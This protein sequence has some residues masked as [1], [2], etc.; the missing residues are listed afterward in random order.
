MKRK[1]LLF[2]VLAAMFLPLAVNAQQALPY[3][4]GFENNNLSADGWTAYVTSSYSGIYS[5]AAHTGSYGFRFN[6]SEEDGYLV[7]PLLTGTDNGVEVSFYYKEYS[8]SYGDEQFYVGYT[9]DESVTDPSAFDYGSI[10]TAST[11]WAQYEN[12]LPAGTKRVA[13][14]YVY[15]DA[16]YLFL[17]DFSFA[18][19]STCPRPKNLA[20]GNITYTTADLSWQ[21]TSN[22]Y[23]L[24]Y[25]PWYQ[26]GEDQITTGV[27]TTY[28]FDLS[29]YSG[30]G[31]VAIRHYDVSDMFELNVDDIVVTNAAGTTLYSQN[32]ETGDIPS[33]ITNLDLD[34]DGHVWGIRSY[35]T[36]A[37]GNA[38]CNGNYC[39][40][41]ASYASGALTPDNWL[42]I[43]GIE[44]GGEITLVARGQD[45]EWAS[46]NFGVFVCPDANPIEV[47]VTTTTYNATGLEPNTPYSWQVKGICDEEETGWVSSFFKTMDSRVVFAYDG[48]WDDPDNWVDA[49][50]NPADVPT[51]VNNV[52]VNAE[53]IIAAGVVALANKITIGEGSI[54]IKDGGQLK[55]NSATVRVTMEKEITGVGEE[56]W[57]ND[58][59]GGFY[60]ISSPFSGRTLFD[61]TSEWNHVEN[62]LE[63]D[64]D[65]YAFDPTRNHLEWINYL[66]EP[67]HIYF[68]S[69]NG[70]A[71]LLYGEGYLYASKEDNLL[72]FK[73]SIGKSN[74]YSETKEYEYNAGA[75]YYLNGW[76]LVGNFFA[77]DAYIN[78]IDDE[79]NVLDADF[80][81]MNA[82]GD[83]Y[84]LSSS[85]VGVPPCTGAFINY[86]ATGKIQ[87]ATEAPETS[88]GGML[89]MNLS[90]GSK[91]LDQARLRFGQGYNLSSM[92]LRANSS[93][94]YMPVED[95]DYAVVYTENQGEMP[96]NFKAE[97]NG[98]YTLS[99]NTEN[100]EFSYLHLIDNMNGND[101]DLLANPSYSFEASTT[102]YASRFKL[103]FAT[104]NADD[105]FAFYSNGSF[106][107]SNEGNATLQVVDV[108]GRIL[109]SETINGCANVN[110]NAAP[111][112]YMLRLIN[113][114][115]VKVQKVVVK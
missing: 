77:C 60:F 111:G 9:T 39:A 51:L 15:K 91:S 55:H 13:I 44:L 62:L 108:T 89:N 66:Y 28:T 115:N 93:R 79:G 31:A 7:S 98:T 25:R 42:I 29:E 34:G 11:A 105:S 84:E 104:G 24:Q 109:K 48:D 14:K 97:N 90:R 67:E 21:G 101:V 73:G 96:V 74:N 8:N 16:W 99:F 22:S 12:T 59:F 106:V 43:S 110:V 33:E 19:P 49:Q 20:A 54:T 71:G 38:Y 92:N 3:S 112:V 81:T 72:V 52:R 82:D 18:V 37:Q 78:Y 35:G 17:D 26:V 47:T 36:D 2:F 53:A 76:R 86:S 94:I 80:Y 70:N 45:P 50:G 1:S 65:F 58:N 87:Y 69:D 5:N 68:Q 41:S 56:N 61:E 57:T 6:Y 46:E 88:K 100:V 95:N 113:G 103:V 32:F 85:V 107:I 40:N 27:L 30:T 23:V 83:G 64:Y 102:D 10:I 4:Y 75:S 63:D 114:N